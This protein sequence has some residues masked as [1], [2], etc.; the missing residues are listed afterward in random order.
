MGGRPRRAGHTRSIQDRLRQ[1]PGLCAAHRRPARSGRHPA[2]G[3]ARACPHAGARPAGDRGLRRHRDGGEPQGQGGLRRHQR[4][5]TGA[6]RRP[7]PRPHRHAGSARRSG[8]PGAGRSQRCARARA[9]RGRPHARHGLP[10]AGR[11]DRAATPARPADDVLLRDA[12]RRGG[13]HRAG[14]HARPRP[15]RDCAARTVRSS[16]KPTIA[17]SPCRRRTGSRC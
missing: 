2:A 4:E 16:R 8:H 1:D 10:A 6:G 12:R 5:G 3:G 17:S 7:R 15:A 14:V 9:R 13:P 11:P